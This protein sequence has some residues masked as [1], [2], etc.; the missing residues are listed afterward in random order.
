MAMVIAFG[1]G[2]SGRLSTQ[3]SPLR[4]MMAATTLVTPLVSTIWALAVAVGS[5]ITP[6][7]LTVV[8]ETVNPSCGQA[9]AR[10]GGVVSPE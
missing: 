2:D 9:S 10:A 6:R 4:S 5:W 1:P 7:R 3:K 8:P